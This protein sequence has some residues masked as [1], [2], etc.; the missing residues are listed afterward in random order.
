VLGEDGNLQTT[1]V[2]SIIEGAEPSRGSSTFKDLT[3]YLSSERGMEMFRIMQISALLWG[4]G[5]YMMSVPTTGEFTVSL[6]HEPDCDSSEFTP[7]AMAAF[8]RLTLSLD[9]QDD[10]KIIKVLA[11]NGVG[12]TVISRFVKEL[13]GDVIEPDEFPG[14]ADLLKLAGTIF[15]ES[16]MNLAA[17]EYAIQRWYME[18]GPAYAD[19]AY[20]EASSSPGLFTIIFFHNRDVSI[21]R[22]QG[23]YPV[24]II[25]PCDPVQSVAA[26]GADEAELPI[27]SYNRRLLNAMAGRMRVTGAELV[28]FC[29]KYFTSARVPVT[30]E[31]ESSSLAPPAGYIE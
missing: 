24:M 3:V 15:T 6:E 31:P 10:H 27:A 16:F 8:N 26:R 7:R 18:N 17:T 20:E 11:P 2:R 28:W 25:P 23:T 21:M 30:N 9:A 5:Q 13:G 22:T 1:I 4:D 12:K 29:Q 14:Y 19:W